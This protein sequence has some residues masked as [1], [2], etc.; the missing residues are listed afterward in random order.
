[1][2]RRPSVLIQK[3]S[4][5]ISQLSY[6]RMMK[7]PPTIIVTTRTCSSRMR[8]VILRWNPM[9]WNCLFSSER[10]CTN[11]LLARGRAVRRAASDALERHGGR[12]VPGEQY[13]PEG[14]VGGEAAGD[15]A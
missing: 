2:A 13:L 6:S 3:A 14:A 15:R 4:A 8:P 9:A 5:L 1:M 12:V 7:I 10:A 11:L